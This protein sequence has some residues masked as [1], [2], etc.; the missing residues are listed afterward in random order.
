MISLKAYN[1]GVNIL[2]YAVPNEYGIVSKFTEFSEKFW[3]D[4]TKKLFRNFQKIVER[5]SDYFQNFPKMKS[6]VLIWNQN[7]TLP[8]CSTCGICIF[9]KKSRIQCQ[10]GIWKIEDHYLQLIRQVGK[11]KCPIKNCNSELRGD[12]VSK[13][14]QKNSNLVEL[15]KANENHLILKKCDRRVQQLLLLKKKMKKKI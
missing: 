14:F 13:H 15:E 1:P 4:E 7:K 11:K 9:K 3:V 5:F 2:H 10:K 6:F 12:D 8:S